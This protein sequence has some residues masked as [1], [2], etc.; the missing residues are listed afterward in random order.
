VPTAVITGGSSGIGLELARL[1]ARR[2]GWRL[3]LAARASDRLAAAAAELGATA[4]PC[5][6]TRDDDVGALAQAADAHGGCDLLLQC[7]GASTGHSFETGEADDYRR[8]LELNY[9]GLVRTLAA[10]W[11]QLVARRGRIVNVAS[12]AGSVPLERSAPYSCSKHAALAW[13]RSLVAPARAQGVTVTTA[14]PGPVPTA[15]FPQSGLVTHG[16]VR[17]LLV[18]DAER[19]ARGILRASDRGRAE[20]FLPARYRLPAA[21]QG[22]APGLVSHLLARP[23]APRVG[24]GAPDA[25]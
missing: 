8:S 12:V 25:A 20:V 11:P 3:L 16:L 6:V 15:G 22:I 14:N 13:S 23:G 18:I 1:L 21:V 10:H 19:C 17:S 24:S 5:D 4:V 2:G 7:A 9:L